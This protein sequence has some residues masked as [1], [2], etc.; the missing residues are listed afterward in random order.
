[1]ACEDWANTKAAYRFFSNGVSE[2]EILRGHFQS[3]K[4]RALAENWSVVILYDMTGFSYKGV[5]RQSMRLL[6]PSYGGKSAQGRLR[7]I[8]RGIQSEP[9][10]ENT[11]CL[12]H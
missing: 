11:F 5:S 3:T 10:K 12:P 6:R 9:A 1:M 8:V 4:G 7:L 2:V